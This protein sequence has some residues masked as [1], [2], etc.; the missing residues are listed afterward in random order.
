MCS[1]HQ[2]VG[3]EQSSECRQVVGHNVYSNPMDGQ[4]IKRVS[5]M[6]CMRYL[7]IVGGQNIE[8]SILDFSIFEDENCTSRLCS[9]PL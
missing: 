6:L 4:G 8:N 9:H 7:I 5:N 1:S 2:P 3:G